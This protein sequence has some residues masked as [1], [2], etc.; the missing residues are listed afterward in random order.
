ME[1][2]GLQSNNWIL[3]D[4]VYN[5]TTSTPTSQSVFVDLNMSFISISKYIIL[6]SQGAPFFCDQNDQWRQGRGLTSPSAATSCFSLSPFPEV[7]LG[8]PLISR[9]SAGS[10]AASTG[11]GVRVREDGFSALQR[12]LLRKHLWFFKKTFEPQS[13]LKRLFVCVLLSL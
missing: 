7:L 6:E 2:T 9:C 10:H 3:S 8:P 13:W 11:A 5:V 4:F 12:T 1:E